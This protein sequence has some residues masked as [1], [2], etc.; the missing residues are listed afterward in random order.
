MKKVEIVDGRS[1]PDKD[2]LIVL[3]DLGF[4][5]VAAF[6]D[7]NI[8]PAFNDYSE[9]WVEIVNLLLKKDKP[10][11][12]KEVFVSLVEDLDA[13]ES[14]LSEYLQELTEIFDDTEFSFVEYIEALGSLV[15]TLYEFS[16]EPKSTALYVTPDMVT[17]AQ[18]VQDNLYGEIDELQEM[19]EEAESD[20][21]EVIETIRR[22]YAANEGSVPRAPKSEE[23]VEKIRALKKQKGRASKRQ[24]SVLNK[25]RRELNEE[26]QAHEQSWPQEYREGLGREYTRLRQEQ[27]SLSN[28]ITELQAKLSDK[29][30][31]TQEGDHVYVLRNKSEGANE[32][33][34]AIKMGNKIVESLNQELDLLLSAESAGKTKKINIP[35]TDAVLLWN[36]TF[37]GLAWK[38]IMI[39]LQRTLIGNKCMT[40]QEWS[41]GNYFSESTWKAKQ[42]AI[43]KQYDSKYGSAEDI[44]YAIKE[45]LVNNNSPRDLLKFFDN[46]KSFN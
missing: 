6:H 21:V 28:Q 34:T 35:Y 19:I 25:Q 1:I 9:G 27:Q 36:N 22:W 15:G 10:M 16:S 7:T 44:A 42:K 18:V 38:N 2:M 32:I 23:I 43:I 17:E 29:E 37:G 14:T 20:Y 46:P 12:D 8:L 26:L 31:E 4:D 24:K 13:L 5:S 11:E 3:N 30:T 40:R 41:A 39:F 45:H 33:K